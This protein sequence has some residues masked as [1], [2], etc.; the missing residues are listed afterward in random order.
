MSGREELF[1][2]S[3]EAREANQS[4]TQRSGGGDNESYDRE[5]I[6]YTAITEKPSPKGIK[7]LRL[8][9]RPIEGR[10]DDPFS[11]R[12][13][14]WSMILGDDGSKFRC[15]WPD[16][17]EHP[18][19][20][21][22]KV[23]TKVMAY[24]YNKADQERKYHYKDSFPEIWNRVAKNND[25]DNS[26]E[27]GWF[28]KMQIMMN[29]I[30]RDIMDWH[31][32][33]KTTVLLSR[34]KSVNDAGITF[35]EP[36]FPPTIYNNIWDVIVGWAG[37]WEDYDVV[38]EAVGSDP[39]YRVYHA[40]ENKR[41]LKDGKGFQVNE[42]V[43]ERELTDEEK[44][45]DR[46]NIDEV[47]PVT[48]YTRI[49][50]RLGVFL[51]EVDKKLGTKFYPELRDLAEKERKEA[52][53]VQQEQERSITSTESNPISEDKETP[54]QDEPKPQPRKVRKASKP[55][56]STFNLDAYADVYPGVSQLTPQER[57]AI[58]GHDDDTKRFIYKEGSYEQL[59][60]CPGVE[61]G[62]CNMDSPEWFHV[63]PGCGLEFE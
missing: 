29:V 22:W 6:P 23:F 58:V 39:W 16:K 8:L 14:N 9:G 51:Q 20:I 15:I 38:I 28:P 53:A 54:V 46:V 40:I 3:R 18:D 31:R 34:K 36:G 49:E 57:E 26:M 62:S 45:W 33:N 27:R 55:E 10:G 19:W 63:C 44:S 4:P 11:P 13:V 12:V 52:E 7:Q 2:K 50:N 24:T 48:T 21:L 1:K 35:F 43:A 56:E 59:Y 41:S 61:D 17:K 32:E 47:L 37:D 42:E 5:P 30:D 25:L 60:S